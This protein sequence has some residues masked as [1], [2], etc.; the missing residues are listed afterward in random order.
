M[1]QNPPVSFPS[2]SGQKSPTEP[3]TQGNNRR[4]WRCKQLTINQLLER[5][6]IDHHFSLEALERYADL[7]CDFCQFI[8]DCL[9]SA[10]VEVTES[11]QRGV[12]VH[13]DMANFDW[14]CAQKSLYANAKE[15]D[16]PS[17]ITFAIKQGMCRKLPSSEVHTI[18]IPGAREV[19][20]TLLVQVGKLPPMELNLVISRG[21]N[22]YLDEYNTYDYQHARHR[23]ASE[24]E[25]MG[26][27]YQDSTLTIF[28]MASEGSEEGFLRTA[29]PPH[30]SPTTLNVSSAAN[31]HTSRGWAFQEVVLS[32]RSLF[33]GARQ[34][35]WQCREGL[36]SLEGLYP[37][38]GIF[39]EKI[40]VVVPQTHGQP[41]RSDARARSDFYTLASEYNMK[42]LT[43]S[44]DKLPAFSGLAQKFQHT[45]GGEYLAGLWSNDIGRGL[46]WL[47]YTPL[48]SDSAAQRNHLPSWSWASTNERLLFFP[49]QPQVFLELHRTD[50]QLCNPQN[51]YGQIRSENDA[52]I[53]SI[54][55]TGMTMPLAKGSWLPAAATRLGQVQFD[56]LEGLEESGHISPSYYPSSTPEVGEGKRKRKVKIKGNV[57]MIYILD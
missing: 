53:P 1:D 2:T 9:K 41:E 17:P 20:E 24:S 57:Q 16:Q 52:T 28:A 46:P 38:S 12:S 34:L 48:S 43:Y 49:P 8:L 10:Q 26:S 45:F 3:P 4:C 23:W 47:L 37:F 35:Y 36:D 29:N 6:R 13:W 32:R 18:E 51:R 19:Y 33:F 31:N 56:V 25:K 27:I 30:P 15:T 5:K 42:A 21:D 55:V 7:G 54:T 40:R 50:I 22:I 14:K 44:S 11:G 39:V